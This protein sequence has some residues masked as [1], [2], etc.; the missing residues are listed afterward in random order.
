MKRII[1]L[2]LA[3]FFFCGIAFNV[4][5]E[6][7]TQLVEQCLFKFGNDTCDSA[8]LL[9]NDN[10]AVASSNW[11]FEYDMSIGLKETNDL[12]HPELKDAAVVGISIIES[13]Q[14]VI[15][16]CFDY[17]SGKSYCAYI[18][19]TGD[20]FFSDL[21]DEE[22]HCGCLVGDKILIAG[23]DTQ[24]EI[25]S[26]WFKVLSMDGSVEYTKVLSSPE[27]VDY[28]GSA[29][30]VQCVA[31]NSYAILIEQIWRGAQEDIRMIEVMPDGSIANTSPID[32]SQ[33]SSDQVKLQ[34]V[35]ALLENDSVIIYGVSPESDGKQSAF[36]LRVDEQCRTRDTVI[37]DNSMYFRIIHMINT[38]NGLAAI[39]RCS[40]HETNS[41]LTGLRLENEISISTSTTER[42]TPYRLLFDGQNMLIAGS[43]FQMPEAPNKTYI[44]LL[45]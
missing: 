27:P 41:I 31:K 37:L 15:I 24:R 5:A 44:G 4:L 36:V 29:S 38:P 19:K 1:C 23:I 7:K 16:P 39:V 42:C 40:D 12:T 18:S 10:V 11:Y 33:F 35:G 13:E 22:I 25:A 32:L 43:I 8:V 2:L 34:I 21:F 28:V 14:Y 20:V 3:C 45:Q 9:T 17:A 26:S 30:I 6:E